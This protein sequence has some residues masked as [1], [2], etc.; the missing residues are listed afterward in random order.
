MSFRFLKFSGVGLEEPLLNIVH[1]HLLSHD[2]FGLSRNDVNDFWGCFILAGQGWN[3]SL[4]NEELWEFS[5]IILWLFFVL[6]SFIF[7]MCHL[8]VN[9][10]SRR[11][12]FL[13]FESMK[14]FC[15]IDPLCPEHYAEMFKHL[16]FSVTVNSLVQWGFLAQ[17]QIPL[18]ALFPGKCLKEENQYDF[19]FTP[20][21]LFSQGSQSCTVLI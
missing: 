2:P 20:L 10:C 19:G 5:V 8:V 11:H 14:F 7:L 18:F 6:G 15:Y 3:F 21:F 1:S 4:P 9:K 17:L 16:G 13:K 12:K